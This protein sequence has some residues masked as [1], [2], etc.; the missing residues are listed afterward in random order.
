MIETSLHRAFKKMPDPRIRRCRQHSLTDIIILS[1][2]ASICGAESYDSIEMFGKE[3]YAF[4]KQIL[5]LKNGIPS[6]DTINRVFAALNPRIFEECFIEWSNNLKDNNILNDVIALDGKTVCNSMDTYHKRNPI[7]LVHAWS[8]KNGICLAQICCEQKSNEIT[9]IP[10]L[11]K[12]LSIEG[13]IITIDAM[14]TQT[15][16]AKQIVD[17]KADYIL[18]VKGN[19]PTLQADVHRICNNNQ[20]V[21]DDTDYDKGHGRIEIRRCQVFLKDNFFDEENRWK[22]VRS[23]I[24][25][26]STRIIQD[27]TTTEERYYISSLKPEEN[28]G[29][30]IRSH[31]AIENSLHHV[32]DVTFREDLQRK[33]DKHAADNF[34]LVR[35]IALN[36]LKKD[37]GKGSL[38]T[39]RLKAAVSLQYL[40]DLLKL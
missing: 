39:K 29:Q 20:P 27:K 31:W 9:A 16:I 28:M 5:E 38:V 24:K 25:I 8:V 21:F 10:E 22:D 32:L 35:K 34:A 36:L 3:R 19:Q 18:A 13:T 15:E 1:I 11:L 23:I 12:L 30:H 14:G 17:G 40:I 33:R 6:H 2:I 4:L 7:H 37:S 26:T